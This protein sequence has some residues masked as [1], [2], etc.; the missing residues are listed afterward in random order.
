MPVI[1]TNHKENKHG[2]D[3]LQ[4]M[5]VTVPSPYPL[6]DCL[7]NKVQ[8]LAHAHGHMTITSHQKWD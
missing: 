7:I 3:L 1:V 2:T 8:R 4:G 5:G 6:L